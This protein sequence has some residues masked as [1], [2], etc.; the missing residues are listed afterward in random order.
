MQDVRLCRL[1]YSKLLGSLFELHIQKLQEAL[2]RNDH[3]NSTSEINQSTIAATQLLS[4]IER[5]KDNTEDSVYRE[6]LEKEL[7]LIRAGIIS[8]FLFNIL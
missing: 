1:M 8:T 7:I 5:E 3:L 6:K 2:F 4:I